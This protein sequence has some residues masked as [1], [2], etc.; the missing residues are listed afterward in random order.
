MYKDLVSF[1]R[2]LYSTNEFIPL[3]APSFQGKEKEYLM[4]TIDSTFVSSVGKFVDQFEEKLTKYTGSQYAIATVNGTSALHMALKLADVE[5]DTEV[6]TQSLTF[7]AT[8]NAI[9]YCLAKPVFVDIDLKTLSISTESLKSFLDEHCEIR[10][11]G[12]CWNKSSNLRISACLPVHTFGFPANA[13]EIKRICDLYRIKMIEDAAE[14][15][16]SYRKHQHTGTIGLLGVV[17][18]NGNKIITT[19]GGGVI[20]TSNEKLA[21][22]AKHLTTTA[23]VK[24][25][26]EIIHD[27]IGYNYRLPN[28]NA[29]LGVAQMENLPD[30]VQNKRWIAQEYQNW[31]KKQGVQFTK[32][33]ADSKANYWLNN[34]I[35]E[36]KNDRDLVLIKTNENGIMTRPA[37]TPMHRLNMYKQ[38]QASSLTNTEW[39]YERLVSVPSSPINRMNTKSD[40]L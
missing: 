38:C 26:S 19:G 23:K 2:S 11:D 6:I 32:E 34:I 29:A 27:E 17:S 25:I 39:L 24:N 14:S 9:R 5:E 3:H 13:E 1:I 31:G 10:D 15:L 12:Y 16:G 40:Y 33:F 28:L 8:C 20:L 36:S 4:E 22:K 37:W 30:Y 7:V 18:F 35:T 21:T